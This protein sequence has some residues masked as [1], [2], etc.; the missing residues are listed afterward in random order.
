MTLVNDDD[1][2]LDA[3]KSAGTS[4]EDSQTVKKH[5]VSK[6]NKKEKIQTKKNQIIEKPNKN[7]KNKK[8]KV[9][10]NTV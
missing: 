1:D 2:R 6:V 10:S 9:K 3:H 8:I 4:Q 7:L 5:T